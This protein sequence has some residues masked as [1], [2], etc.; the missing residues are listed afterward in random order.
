MPKQL[1]FNDDARDK[2]RAGVDKLANTVK[3]TLGPKGRNVV[4]DKGFGAPVITNDGV[5]IAKDIELPDKYENVGVELVKQVAEKTNDVAGDGTTTA[6]ILAQAMFTEGLKNLAAG[7]NPMV[8]RRGIEKATA[9]ATDSLNEQKRDVAGK[10]EIA[11]VATI[12]AQDAEVGQLISD[13]MEKVTKDGVITVEESQTLGLESEVVEGMQF[14][15]GYISPYMV[16]NT[17]KM[18]AEIRDPYI[19]ITDKKISAVADLLPLLEKLMQ[20]GKKELV[21]IAEDVEGEALATLVVNKIRGIF[22]AIAVKAPGFGDR[23]KELLSDIATLTGGQVISEEVGLK[24][25]TVE[26]DMLG[27]ADRVLANKDETTLVGGKGQQKDIDARVSQIRQAIERETSD[28]DKE[29]LQERLAKLAS[30]VAV[31][32]VGAA[33]ETEQKE[34]QHRVEDAVSATKAAVEEGIV[35]GGGLALLL[36]AEKVAAAVAEEEGKSSESVQRDMITG[37]R[38]V[39]RALEEPVR[40]IAA[41]AGREGSVIV[42][43][44]RKQEFKVGYDA[45]NHVYVNMFD[46]GIVDPKMVTRSALQNAASIASIMLTTEAIVTDIPE[47]RKDM[48]TP[49]DMGGMM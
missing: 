26:L 8:L 44:L 2:L 13:V 21:I 1:A 22:H 40:Q 16:T 9:V 47:E 4:L 12:S 23:R 46:A 31:I 24:L 3:V 11:Q 29:K 49:P 37:M 35:A 10:G 45:H 33:T 7:A 14:D 42:E 20:A 19:L 27:R 39:M 18:E 17:E 34:K 28:F 36:A 38:L 15:K 25:E 5:T 6:T 32:R 30:G 41:N 43:E 48:P